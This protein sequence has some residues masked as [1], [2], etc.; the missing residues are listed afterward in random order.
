ME[1]SLQKC[2]QQLSTILCFEWVLYLFDQELCL[3]RQVLALKSHLDIDK[4]RI[5]PA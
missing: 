5:A 1:R 4:T 3:A 2:C